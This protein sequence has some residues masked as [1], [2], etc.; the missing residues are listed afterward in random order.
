MWPIPAAV[1][2][3]MATK[4]AAN[5]AHRVKSWSDFL[6]IIPSFRWDLTFSKARSTPLLAIAKKAVTQNRILGRCDNYFGAIAEFQRELSSS[7]G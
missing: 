2:P 6:D 4:P 7:A 3:A 5:F 1:T